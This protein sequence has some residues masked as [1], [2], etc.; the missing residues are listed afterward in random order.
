MIFRN[1]AYRLRL[2]RMS[3]QRFSHRFASTVRALGITVDVLTVTAA[4]VCSVGMLIYVGF[5]HSAREF[6]ILERIIHCGQG[7]F[8]LNIV[9]SLLLTPPRR[10]T[11]LQRII[12]IAVCLTVLPLIIHAHG[13]Y[14]WQMIGSNRVT[15][16]VIAVYSVVQLSYAIMRLPGKRTNPSLIL[17]SSF[18]LFIIVGT[19]ALML[20]KSTYNGIS[21]VDSLFVAT[22][23]VSITGLTPVDVAATFTPLGLTILG[24]LIEV[25]A[26]GVITFTCFFAMFFTGNTSIYSQLIV[27]DIIYSKSMS[28]LLPTMLYVLT[29]TLTVQLIGAVALYFSVPDSLQF[30][31]E[32]RIGFAVFHSVSAF[33]NAG[34]SSLPD[35]LS[36]PALMN[37]G[38]LIY[39]MFSL[40]IIAGA[41]GFPIIINFRD[42][43]ADLLGFHRHRRRSRFM[44]PFV[45]DKKV[46]LFNMNTKIVLTTTGTLFAIGAIGF[47]IL[48]YDRSLAGMSLCDKITQSVFNS[49]TPRSA[50]FSSIAPAQFAAPTLIMILFMMWVGG[51]AQSTA[52]GVKVNT[53]AAIVLN[54]RSIVKGQSRVVA[55]RRT[56]ATASIR[57]ANAMV[58]VSLITYT[59][60]SVIILILE[61]GLPPRAVLFETCSALFTVGSSLGITA[62]LGPAAETVLCV[63]M[64]LGRVGIVSLLSGI[65]SHRRAQ[66]HYPTDNIII[67]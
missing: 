31:T 24:V 13:N 42:A 8:L 66:P 34:F 52:G 53:L 20:P 55:F 33:C 2:T 47:F 38:G 56:I 17:T 35:G 67:N 63:A 51:S 48:E 64:L 23:A 32:Q 14:L 43:L 58:S 28:S 39:W 49:V 54:L 7:V 30:D 19:L 50:G 25:G 41:I 40:I 37:S 10:R 3:L 15:F 45:D 62:E 5:D 12:N 60:L 65:L 44:T 11:P 46:H 1:L 6:A 9:Y 26:L 29:T 16:A 59:L 4:L 22:S 57:R 21:F 36:N 18:M 61:P 27:R